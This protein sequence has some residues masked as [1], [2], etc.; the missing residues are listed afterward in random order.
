MIFSWRSVLLLVGVVQGLVVATMLLTRK[1]NRSANR[2]LAALMLAFVGALMPQM[3]GFGGMYDRFPW[4]S[5]APFDVSLAF[6]PLLYLYMRRLL[7]G[8]LT[9]GQW[10]PH[11]APSLLQFS[12]YTVLFGLPLATKSW[13]VANVHDPR[14]VPLETGAALASAFGY[15][16]ATAMLYREY[17][18]WVANEVSDSENYHLTWL[19]NLLT[20]V[21]ATFLLWLGFEAV[22]TI[23]GGIGYRERFWLFLWAAAVMY[24]LGMA[25]YRYAELKFPLM[26]ADGR[27]AKAVVEQPEN[28]DALGEDVAQRVAAEE[29]FLDPDLTLPGLARKMATNTWTLSR[30][31]NRGLELNFND[32]VNQA[33]VDRVREHLSDPADGRSLLEIALDCGFNSKTSFNRSFK[34]L[35]GRTPSSF[36]NAR[37]SAK[38]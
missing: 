24:Y 26:H 31:I 27:A 37:R 3:L 10:L 38:S 21:A 4:L 29:W 7:T 20:V 16:C 36:R 15:W 9:V 1:P 19:R 14:V 6:G 34:K 17:R 28:W 35:T 8:P 12:Y 22:E 18:L 5:Q 13:F 11:L 30:A 23:R 33:R 25:S 2:F 32:F